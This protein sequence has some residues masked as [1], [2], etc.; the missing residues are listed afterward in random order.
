MRSSPLERIWSST[1]SARTGDARPALSSR[2]VAMMRMDT[3]PLEFL[4]TMPSEIAYGKPIALPLASI[5]HKS[6]A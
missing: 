4:V 5:V 6:L 3:I 2:T 1:A